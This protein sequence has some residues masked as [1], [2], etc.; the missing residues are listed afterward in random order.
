MMHYNK[1]ILIRL[2]STITDSSGRSWEALKKTSDFH[3]LINQR[4]Q[5]KKLNYTEVQFQIMINNMS[6]KD[7]L[8]MLEYNELY[9][10]KQIDK[11]NSKT[12]KNQNEIKAYENSKISESNQDSQSSSS[13]TSNELR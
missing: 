13:K 11:I 9:F 10:K 4:K 2:K 12:H 6:K 1:Q 8:E 3:L 7:L 5:N